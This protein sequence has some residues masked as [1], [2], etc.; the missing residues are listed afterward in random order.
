MQWWHYVAVN[1]YGSYGDTTDYTDPYSTGHSS[2]GSHTGFSTS[3]MVSL[4]SGFGI[5]W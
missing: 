1:G 4:V 5:V 2:L 3:S